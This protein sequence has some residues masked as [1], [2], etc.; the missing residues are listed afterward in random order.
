MNFEKRLKQQI[1][2]K[3]DQQ[4][5]NPY[6]RKRFPL[7]AK[8]MIPVTAVTAAVAV[9]I[10]I[11]NTNKMDYFIS[12]INGSYIDMANVA[13][14]GI[15]NTP[16]N[17]GKAKIKKMQ[18]LKNNDYMDEQDDDDSS[19][20]SDDQRE[21]YDW[22]S[23]YDWDP[24]KA[25]VL[26]TL[27]EN[28]RVTEVIYE[29]TNGRGQVRQEHL[30][31]AAA[32]F[33]SKSFTYVMYVNDSTWD[34]YKEIDYAQ[35]LRQPSGFHVHH[36]EMQTIVIHNE[37]GKV[38][39]LK[40]LLTQISQET[41]VKNYTMQADPTRDDF[42]H[43]DPPYGNLEQMK[44]RF[45][46]VRWNDEEQNIIYENVLPENSGYKRSH[47]AKED[48]YGQLYVLADDEGYDQ[49]V[50]LDKNLEIKDLSANYSIIDKTLIVKKTNSVFFGNDN[51][52]YV[53]QYDQLKVFGENFE[54]SP[55][56]PETVVNFEGMANEFFSI[57][58]DT[59]WL[60]GSCFH[61]ENGYL[62]SA[63]GEVWQVDSDGAMH[64]SDDLEGSFATYTNDAFMIGG[65]IVA[66]VDTNQNM[67]YSVDGRIVQ[68][69]F[70]LK[71]GVPSCEAK[72]VI[73]AS[74]YQ[75]YGHRI[76]IDQDTNG[77][78]GGGSAKYYLIMVI[79]GKACAQ[80]IA[81][82]ANGGMSGVA[83]TISEPIDLT[84]N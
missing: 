20:W 33:V 26:F 10:I 14:F 76:V 28:G 17:N 31:N 13:G 1:T 69:E 9:P 43:V 80:Y 54:L 30:G 82:G 42:I 34:F 41:G 84:V 83:G 24:D 12:K 35:E 74:F 19:S 73:N 46:K 70:S 7:L 11:M 3:L 8:I 22:E 72:H 39:A 38:F 44:S 15:G 81:Y 67:H 63:L 57:L 4:V 64:K 27:D 6:K 49:T 29:M 58:N 25:N 51:R 56:E 5:P 16:T 52:A 47:T 79:D 32:M 21:Y 75:S 48:K 2:K 71:D 60:N 18:Y 37:T 77:G 68:L 55:I 23:D 36:N 53:V 61:Y 50:R 78:M 59:G 65:E 45:Y 40:D 66:F 62:F